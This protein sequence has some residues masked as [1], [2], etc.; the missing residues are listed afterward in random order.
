MEKINDKLDSSQQTTFHPSN[1]IFH[2]SFSWTLLPASHCCTVLPKQT[3]L[4]ANRHPGLA[5]IS[6][7]WHIRNASAHPW[8]HPSFH[9]V[10][11]ISEP[12]S[13]E[14][15]TYS[16]VIHSL[17]CMSILQC[18]SHCSNLIDLNL[19]GYLLHFWIPRS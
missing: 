8:K 10:F 11:R 6:S 5:P 1:I 2:Q 3:M 9:A 4:N 14:V 18:F 12:H 19:P 17:L 15:F 13:L 16:P 7:H